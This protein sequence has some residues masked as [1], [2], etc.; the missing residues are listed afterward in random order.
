MIAQFMF[1]AV[2]CMNQQCAFT[3]SQHPIPE[4]KCNELKKQFLSL[5]FKPDVTLAATQCLDFDDSKA[6]L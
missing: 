1:V 2:V 6:R 5:P 4:A 3:M